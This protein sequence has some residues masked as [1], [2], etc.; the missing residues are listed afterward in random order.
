MKTQVGDIRRK[1]MFGA[2]HE[3]LHTKDNI[4]WHGHF[5]LPHKSSWSYMKTLKRCVSPQMKRSDPV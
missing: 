1:E 5:G 4:Q 3:P 2:N